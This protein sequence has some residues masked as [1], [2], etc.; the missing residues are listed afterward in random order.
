L[1]SLPS[2]CGLTDTVA[3]IL[4]GGSTSSR[5]EMKMPFAIMRNFLQFDEISWKSPD[6][7]F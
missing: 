5:V 1:C 2:P 7:F 3:T 4:V 6:F